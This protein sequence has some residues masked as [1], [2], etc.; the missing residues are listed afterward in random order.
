MAEQEE[1]RLREE[2]DRNRRDQDLQSE[3][4]QYIPLIKG[5][6]QQFWVRPPSAG[7][8]LSV[9]V[10]LR[11]EPSGEVVPGSVRVVRGSGLPS[12]DQSAIAAIYR[13]S[14]LPVPTGPAFEKLREFNFRFTP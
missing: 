11:L 3:A 4:E 1:R 13:A 2:T 8:D 5:R 14:P 9:L 10:S 7:S 6:I 12:F